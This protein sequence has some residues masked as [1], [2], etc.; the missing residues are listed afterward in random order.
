MATSIDQNSDYALISEPIQNIEPNVYSAATSIDQQSN[1]E[2]NSE[3]IQISEPHV[4]SETAAV[5]TSTVQQ[6]KQDSPSHGSSLNM[7]ANSIDQKS[8]H[9]LNSELIQ[10]NEP[11]FCLETAALDATT[12]QQT[13]EDFI[14][15]PSSQ[16]NTN[17]SI[18]NY[19]KEMY[20]P[21]D[22]IT[23]NNVYYSNNVSKCPMPTSQNDTTFNENM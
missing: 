7:I 22:A 8:N 1:H 14:L 12:V 4:Y 3:T 2:L 9:E 5:V 17:H 19:R 20:Q 10:I 15:E 18:A 6:P 23:L 13:K 16:I 21:L 11:Y